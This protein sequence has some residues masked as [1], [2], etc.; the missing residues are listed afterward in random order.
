MSEDTSLIFYFGAKAGLGVQAKSEVAMSFFE[1]MHSK[2]DPSTGAVILPQDM[3]IWGGESGTAEQQT[4]CKSNL[5][6]RFKADPEK[7]WGQNSAEILQRQIDDKNENKRKAEENVSNF[8]ALK[9]QIVAAVESNTEA[10]EI[11]VSLVEPNIRCVK[12]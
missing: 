7:P 5:I 11:Y 9:N 12:A 4:V 6:L 3:L 10:R 2:I 8:L 1:T